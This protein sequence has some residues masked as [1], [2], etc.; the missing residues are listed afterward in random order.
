MSVA[1]PIMGSHELIAAYSVSEAYMIGEV[2]VE[3][4]KAIMDV[5]NGNRSPGPFPPVFSCLMH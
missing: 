1:H 2:E 3:N 5:S 4:L